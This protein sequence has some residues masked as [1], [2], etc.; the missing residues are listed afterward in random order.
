MPSPVGSMLHQYPRSG[1]PVHTPSLHSVMEISIWNM[2]D[3]SYKL[4]SGSPWLPCHRRG[5][6]GH[7]WWFW[8]RSGRGQWCPPSWSPGRSRTWQTA[9]PLCWGCMAV[10]GQSRCTGLWGWVAWSAGQLVAA[11]GLRGGNIL[12]LPIQRH[13]W[14]QQR[15]ASPPR[16]RFLNILMQTRGIRG[17]YWPLDFFL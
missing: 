16:I 7:W 3:T 10:W 14:F 12:A 9:P 6:S 13:Y 15:D 5:G 4:Q 11:P 17:H 8:P 2:G 1:L